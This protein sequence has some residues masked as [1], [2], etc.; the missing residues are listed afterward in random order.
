MLQE[1]VPGEIY[2]HEAL[3]NT[4]LDGVSLS[5]ATRSIA[6]FFFLLFPLE[7]RSHA[8]IVSN[9]ELAVR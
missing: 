6:T 4:T 1:V 2:L 5:V 7:V 9:L 3:E 8:V